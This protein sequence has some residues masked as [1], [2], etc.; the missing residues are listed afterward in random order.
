MMEHQNLVIY[1]INRTY[2]SKDPLCNGDFYFRI[3]MV[4]HITLFGHRDF[5]FL[6]DE[7]DDHMAN[8]YT[9]AEEFLQ[10]YKEKIDAHLNVYILFNSLYD[11]DISLNRAFTY[12]YH[13]GISKSY[14]VFILSLNPYR[15]ISTYYI[16]SEF[17]QSFE[18][19]HGIPRIK[20]NK[21][22]HH[23]EELLRYAM[24]LRLG[25]D[26]VNYKTIRSETGIP[27][28]TIHDFAHSKGIELSSGTGRN[29]LTEEEKIKLNRILSNIDTNTGNGRTV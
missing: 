23:P 18:S 2:S 16:N 10:K 27:K 29:Y 3:A 21:P 6:V 22:R 20:R 15:D 13:L 14:E 5:D 4:W 26:L 17:G 28:A 25:D 1:V 9:D 24:D 11:I 12:L 8:C 7:N 19:K